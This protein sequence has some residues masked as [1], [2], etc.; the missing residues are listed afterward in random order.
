MLAV[1]GFFAVGGKREDTSMKMML[2]SKMFTAVATVIF[3]YVS[4]LYA[5]YAIMTR[6]ISEKD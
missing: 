4:L 3:T 2:I 1:V 6:F 5:K